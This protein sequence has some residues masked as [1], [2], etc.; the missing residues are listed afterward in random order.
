M[1]VVGGGATS[2]NPH[3]PGRWMGLLAIPTSQVGKLRLRQHSNLLKFP[4]LE[5]GGLGF[6][7]ETTISDPVWTNKTTYPPFSG[8][9]LNVSRNPQHPTCS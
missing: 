5:G 2:L 7:T 3:P 6:H 4:W 9:H 8:F 1:G